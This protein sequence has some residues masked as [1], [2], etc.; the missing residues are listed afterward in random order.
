M[1]DVATVEQLVVLS[2]LESINAVKHQ[3]LAAPERLTQLNTIAICRCTPDWYHI[4]KRLGMRRS[5]EPI[6]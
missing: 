2:K 5:G 4:R 3:G 1:H 6:F